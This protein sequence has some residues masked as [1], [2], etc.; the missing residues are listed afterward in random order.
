MERRKKNWESSV[1]FMFRSARTHSLSPSLYIFCPSFELGLVKPFVII[2]VAYE[3]NQYDIATALK[4][5]YIC[6]E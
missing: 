6:K 1:K 3:S 5:V 2:L 4:K